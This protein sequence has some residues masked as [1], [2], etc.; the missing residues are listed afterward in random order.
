MY[1][2]EKHISEFIEDTIR[3]VELNARHGCKRV[4]I[5]IPTAYLTRADVEGPL[6][7]TFP[8]CKIKWIWFLQS[9]KIKW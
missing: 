1:N 5:D 2:K 6:K 4:I 8:G 9:Y 3:E 7:E